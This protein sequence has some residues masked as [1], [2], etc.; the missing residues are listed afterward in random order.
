[1]NPEKNKDVEETP[2]PIRVTT[3]ST[4]FSASGTLDTSGLQYIV[5]NGLVPTRTEGEVYYSEPLVTCARRRRRVYESIIRNIVRHHPSLVLFMC[6][7]HSEA[8]EG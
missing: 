2:K 5:S 4:D 1:M 7:L 6:T 8:E 3:T